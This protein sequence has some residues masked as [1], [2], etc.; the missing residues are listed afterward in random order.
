MGVPTSEVGYTSATARRRDH[1]SPYEHVVALEKDVSK[2]Q[3]QHTWLQA[4]SSFYKNKLCLRVNKHWECR[5]R[6]KS[7][8]R[9]REKCVT[10]WIIEGTYCGSGSGQLARYSKIKLGHFLEQISGF[11][12]LNKNCLQRQTFKA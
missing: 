2:K 8:C 3:H 12:P 9:K 6:G 10:V 11:Q 5:P 1:E 7:R 4:S